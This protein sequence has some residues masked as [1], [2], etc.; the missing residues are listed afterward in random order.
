MN[1]VIYVRVSSQDQVEGTSLESQELACREY[2]QRHNLKVAS[3]FVEQGESAKFADRTQL[4]ALLD[5]CRVKDNAVSVL[6]VWKLDRF[7]RNVEDHFAIKATLRRYG[8]SVV[9]VTEPIAE[10]ANGR[11]LETIL[12][13]FAA[14]DNDVRAMRSIQGMQQKLREGLF[15][16][17]PPLGYLPPKSGR[18]TEADRPDPVRF[19][20]LKK[21]WQLYATGAYT[22]RAIL[23]HLQDWGVFGYRTGSLSP[24]TI[25]HI[26]RNPYYAGILKDPWSGAEYTGRHV[27]MVSHE[28]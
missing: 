3:V 26:F 23:R 24:Q 14:F 17:K 21:A 5:Y 9:S 18:K 25:D 4:L 11:L 10:D 13:G 22:K 8:V 28:E 2:A 20:P 1:A 7:A 15:P 12:A 19:E 16:W 6:I 27:P